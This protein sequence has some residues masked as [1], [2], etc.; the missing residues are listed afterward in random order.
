PGSGGTC[1]SARE[2]SFP[3]EQEPGI[4]ALQARSSFSVEGVR[5]PGAEIGETKRQVQADRQEVRRE[6]AP[7]P[8]QPRADRSTRPGDQDGERIEAAE[9]ESLGPGQGEPCGCEAGEER[10]PAATVAFRQGEEGERRREAGIERIFEPGDRPDDER[11]L[12]REEEEGRGARQDP[13][14]QPG[15]D[16]VEQGER[17]EG[18]GER[19]QLRRPE[20][21]EEMER[22]GRREQE[23]PERIRVT[24][25]RRQAGLGDQAV[26]RGEVARVDERDPG[27]V[28]QPAAEESGVKD[29][30]EARREEDRPPRPAPLGRRRA[31]PRFPVAH[32]SGSS[33]SASASTSCAAGI[34]PFGSRQRSCIQSHSAGCS[35]ISLSVVARYRSVSAAT[36]SAPSPAGKIGSRTTIRYRP[37]GSANAKI[38]R[39]GAPVRSESRATIGLVRAGRPKK[40]TA[41]ASRGCTRWSIRMPTR[42]PPRRIWIMRRAAPFLGITA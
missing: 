34:P 9:E 26:A 8:A 31:R 29:E 13:E 4:E 7:E 19:E 32:A 22:R 2:S 20:R 37:P 18:E 16:P 25:D 28:D 42:P 33:V 23:D 1:G 11:G 3:P 36:A 41:I 39:T 17:S 14:P 15:E 35:R 6:V 24:L 21:I 40:G 38:G 5:S 30:G 27:V 12:R 10:N